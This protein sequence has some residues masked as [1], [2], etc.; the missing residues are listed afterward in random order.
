MKPRTLAT[1][2]GQIAASNGRENAGGRVEKAT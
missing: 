1:V 2:A